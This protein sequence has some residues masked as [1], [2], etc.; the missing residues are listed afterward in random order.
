[1]NKSTLKK[2]IKSQLINIDK[3][4]KP[5]LI[6]FKELYKSNQIDMDEQTRARLNDLNRQMGLLK[7]RLAGKKYSTEQSRDKQQ[8][9]QIKSQLIDLEKQ[10]ESMLINLEKKFNKNIPINKDENLIKQLS[11]RYLRDAKKLGYTDRK[12]VV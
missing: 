3:Q 1:M 6:R 9:K 4:R 8:E 7:R 11:N 12:S 10:Y 5:G 2:R